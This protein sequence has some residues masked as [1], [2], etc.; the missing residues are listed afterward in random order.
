MATEIVMPQLGLTMTEG[1]IVK[2]RKNVCDEVK[3][4]EVLAEITTDKITNEIEAPCDGVVLMIKVPEGETVPVKSLIALIGTEGEAVDEA[5]QDN[6]EVTADKTEEV[7]TEDAP[8]EVDAKTT[9]EWI[10]ASPAARKLA[11]N[12]NIDLA[13]ITATGPNDRIVERD[14]KS[15]IESEQ[16]V[17]ITPL[18]AKAAQEHG[19]DIHRI[20]VEG[21]ITKDDV[22]TYV[23]KEVA[24]DSETKE[25][26]PLTGMRKVIAE[27]MTMS[28]QTTPHVNMTTEVDMLAASELKKRIEKA[29]GEKVSFTEIIVKCVAKA[30]SEF[31]MLNNSIVN[32]GVKVN[33]DINIGVAVAISN[34]L[35]V[36]VI[37]NADRLSISGLKDELKKTVAKAR[38]GQF[39]PDDLTGGTFTISNLGMLG[40]DQFTPVI[41]PP[42]A[43]ILGVCRMVEKPIVVNGE[44]IVR[45]RMNLCLSFD[46]RLIDGAL[47]A[48]FLQRISS[49]LEEPLLLI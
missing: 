18:A 16:Q 36:P 15:F 35:V 26:E 2:W 29:L 48:Q 28:W 4:G 5:T 11:R 43:A 25:I 49:F 27:R 1:T 24:A 45:P 6:T 34:G 32:N 33:S 41:N 22:M 17:R 3:T 31:K 46:H 39:T 9:G 42:E 30:L 10:K 23:Q 40:V 20:K 21:R 38:E 14:V 47:A 37:R 7:F 13:L 44:I 8:I 19:V 12:N